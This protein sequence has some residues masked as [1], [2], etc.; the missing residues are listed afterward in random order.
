MVRVDFICNN[1]SPKF[2]TYRI[3][4]YMYI[5]YWRFKYLYSKTKTTRMPRIKY[6]CQCP[7][8]GTSTS[9]K[10]YQP[11]NCN[12]MNVSLMKEGVASRPWNY[13]YLRKRRERETERRIYIYAI[14]R[15]MRELKRSRMQERKALGNLERAT[16]SHGW[17]FP[18][19]EKNANCFRNIRRRRVSAIYIYVCVCLSKRPGVC[20][21]HEKATSKTDDSVANLVIRRHPARDALRDV[22]Y[23]H[24]LHLS[25]LYFDYAY[26]YRCPI[27][28]AKYWSSRQ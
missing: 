13:K 15:V 6:Q 25:T 3:Y 27:P 17:N 14:L 26:I 16:I 8:I 18:R 1:L 4:V 23:I 20:R 5:P 24:V 11:W 2:P 10:L 21:R 22:I 7:D 28:R 19:V 12:D 9:R